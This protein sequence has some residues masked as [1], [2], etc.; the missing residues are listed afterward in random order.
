MTL[1]PHDECDCDAV[2][3][4]LVRQLLQKTDHSEEALAIVRAI[5]ER[6]ATLMIERPSLRDIWGKR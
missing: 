1:T 5:K 6:N 2:T 3:D 4:Q